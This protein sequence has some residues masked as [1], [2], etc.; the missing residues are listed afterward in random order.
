MKHSVTPYAERLDLIVIWVVCNS[1]FHNV[2]ILAT[3]P[4]APSL[5]STYK[6]C[7][8]LYLLRNGVVNRTME[9]IFPSLYSTCEIVPVVQRQVKK[10]NSNFSLFLSTKRAPKMQFQVKLEKR[11][12]QMWCFRGTD[13]QEIHTSGK[14]SSKVQILMIF[15]L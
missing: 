6:T 10:Y 7:V 11:Q 8:V 1:A 5:Q 13:Y 14:V 4:S 9:V 12:D 15:V 3:H 2:C